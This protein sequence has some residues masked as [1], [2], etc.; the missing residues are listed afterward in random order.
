M[1]PAAA[2]VKFRAVARF[3][4]DPLRSIRVSGEVRPSVVREVTGHPFLNYAGWLELRKARCGPS[5]G[6]LSPRP[7]RLRT[8]N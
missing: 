1:R 2:G 3:E 7:V 4:A 5:F 8:A 6:P